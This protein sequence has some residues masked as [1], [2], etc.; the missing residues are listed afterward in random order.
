M[1]EQAYIGVS[2]QYVVETAAGTITVYVQ[3]TDPGAQ[4]A[5]PGDRV[6]LSWSPDATVVSVVE[7]EEKTE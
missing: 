7:K 6:T 4:L 5:R 3:N 1:K 2:T